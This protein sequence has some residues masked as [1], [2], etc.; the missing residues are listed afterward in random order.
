MVQLGMDYP[1]QWSRRSP[2]R[3]VRD[4]VQSLFIAPVS[5]SFTSLDVRGSQHLV[6]EG[7]FVLASN[8][9]SHLDTPIVLAALPS[10]IR[11]HTVVAAALDT[12]FEQRS[13]AFMAVLFFNAIPIDRHKINRRSGEDAL[14]LLNDGWTLLIYPEG[15][16]SPDGW[17]QDFKGGAAYLADRASA[18]VIPTYIDGIGGVLGPRYAKAPQYKAQKLRFRHHVAVA[19]G[20]P[21]AIEEGEKLRR[22]SARIEDAV[23]ALGRDVSGDPTYGKQPA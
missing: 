16:R 4:G 6:G 7:P 2:A 9:I 1:T 3:Y 11:R 5:R 23:V 10:R 18:K 19:F 17:L 13:K 14:A 12:F 20:E 15:G 22:F 21:L 8:H